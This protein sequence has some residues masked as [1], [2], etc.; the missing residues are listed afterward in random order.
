MQP[1]VNCTEVVKAW[2]GLPD[3]N[4]STPGM[5][6]PYLDPVNIVTIGYGHV[7][8]DPASGKP[9][10]GVAGLRKAA[11]IFPTGISAQQAIQLLASDIQETGDQLLL[12]RPLVGPA[13]THGQFDGLVSFAFNLGVGTLKQSTLL[14]L[15][16]Q[17]NAPLGS[18]PS[19]DEALQLYTLIVGKQ[20]KLTS[21]RNAFVAFSFAKGTPYLGLFAR[22]LS[23]YALYCGLSGIDAA[24]FGADRRDFIQGASRRGATITPRKAAMRKRPSRKERS[25]KARAKRSR[26]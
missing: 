18:L 3:G 12:P 15:H 5:Y 23:E 9:L 7:V 2:E 4:P 24:R 26:R 20:L 13:T 25:A 8:T 19:N 16:N 22:R 17:G 6:D 1:S 14:R 21:I 11:T 10:L